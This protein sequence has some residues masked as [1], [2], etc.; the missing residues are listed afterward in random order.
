V[1]LP[2]IPLTILLLLTVPG[3]VV[4]QSRSFVVSP[5]SWAGGFFAPRGRL[6]VT[7]TLGNGYVSGSTFGPAVTF[8]SPYGIAETQI[9]VPV[10]GRTKSPRLPAPEVDLSGV[11]L[12]RGPPPWA[13]NVDWPKR[14]LVPAPK[15]RA[16]EM[17]K[18]PEA[19]KDLP[20]KL[21]AADLAAPKAN[22]IEEGQRLTT[23]GVAAFRGREYGLAARKFNQALD[24]DP[25]ASR[26]YFFLSEAYFA[27][28][29]YSDAVQMA[30][31]GLGLDPTWPKSPFR[32][33][34]DLYAEH[35][36]DW[37]QHMQRLE[38]A[39]ARQPNNAGYVFLLAQQRWFDEQRDEAVKL[40][41]QVRPLVA[42]PALVDLF[43]KAAD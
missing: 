6:V 37:Q 15:P 22:P 38:D 25:T 13:K 30:G 12:D 32:P 8:G 35:P 42:D 40:F 43:L 41:R 4:A 39:R 2:R 26:T 24:V 21:P 1:T 19:L 3:S 5:G 17:V 31:V 29:K 11:D 9:G 18:P 20:P 23:L 14:E 16:E 7:T 10:V 27:L 36:E 33:R 28:G 34:F